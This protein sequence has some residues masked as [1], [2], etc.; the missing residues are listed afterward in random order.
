MH[1]FKTKKKMKIND[2]DLILNPDGSIFHLHLLPQDISDNII[3]VGDPSRV[4]LVASFFDAVELVKENRE[5]KTITG[6]YGNKRIT[7]IS[8]GIGTDNIDIVINELDALVNVDLGTKEEKQEHRK[9]NF[10]RIGTCGA[11]QSDIEIGDCI[12][13]EK[14]IGFDGVLNFYQGRDKVSDLEFEN[15]LVDYLKLNPQIA[16]PYVVSA[17]KDLLDKISV[18]P[19]VVLGVNISANGFYGPQSRRLRLKPYDMNLNSKLESFRY[20]DYR[21]TNYEME[22]SAIYGLSSLLGHSAA[23]ICLVIANRIGKSGDSDYNQNMKD[24]IRSI[25][26][27]V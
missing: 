8:T 17:S 13:S 26:S 20:G 24:L 2:S 1:I 16:A 7:V 25:L 27:I 18:L 21:I 22:S 11:L 3:L 5:F 23:T 6:Y 14:S 10:I 12:L 9:L 4:Q 15:S 19:H